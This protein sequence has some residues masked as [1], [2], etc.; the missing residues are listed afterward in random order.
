MASGIRLSTPGGGMARALKLGGGVLLTWG[1]FL[2]YSHPE[3]VPKALKME[4][5]FFG[6]GGGFLNHTRGLPH[7]IPVQPRSILLLGSGSLVGLLSAE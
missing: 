7:I 2:G 1:G 3:G 5:G 4:G 6:L